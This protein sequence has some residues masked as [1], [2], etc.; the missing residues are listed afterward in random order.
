MG[1]RGT[2]YQPGNRKSELVP[3]EQPGQ[4]LERPLL[5]YER[6]LIRILGC[7]EREYRSYVK[8]VEFKSKE[9][10][11][12]YELIPDISCAPAV[13]ILINLAIG[14]ALTAVA[15]LLAPKPQA[16]KSREQ[17]QGKD[18]RLASKQGGERFGATSGF[19]SINDLANFAEP[20][21]VIFAK[22]EQKIG[23]VLAAGQLVWSRAYSYGSGQGL[24]LMYII[25]EQGLLGEGIDRP[26]LQGIYLGTTALDTLSDSK[27]AFYWNR[28]T[29]INGRIKAKNLAYGTRA[30]PSA[31]DPQANDDIFLCPSG[32]AANDT[33]FSQSYT[34]TSNSIFGCYGA[35][36][37]G[38]GYRV[39]FE[40]V[41]LPR[42][43]GD[44]NP[45]QSD[46]ERLS[47]SIRRRQK[48]SGDYNS[49]DDL[50]LDDA[51]SN[52]QRG[53]G[54]E[55][56]RHMGLY[57]LNNQIIAPGGPNGHKVLA[58]VKVGDTA[59]FVIEGGF[60]SEDKYWD[61]DDVEDVNTD[62]INNAT[63]RLR[64]EADDILQVGQ[65][66]MIGQTVW[67][68]RA[69]T[70]ER[71]GLEA[72]GKPI[73][74][75]FQRRPNQD[76]TLEC[77]ESFAVDPLRRQIGFVSNEAITRSIRT[78]DQGNKTYDYNSD[79]KIGL[80]IGPGFFPLMQVN[81]A[82]V[83][84]TRACETT[85]FGIKS[86]VWNRASGLCNFSSLP[87]PEGLSEA[88]SRGDSFRSGVMNTYFTRSS[89]FTIFLRPA[90]T[91][92]DGKEYTWTPI[93][94]Q[95]VVT[96]KR[97]VDQYN[98]LRF[99]HPEIREY[100]FKFVPKPGAD[101]TQ[102]APD[103][104]E[105]IL[106]D[107]TLVNFAQQGANF[108]RNYST[109]YGTFLVQC[110]G[111]PILKGSIEF[112]PE[113]STGVK[114]N[115]DGKG[116]V[117]AVPK[118]IIIAGYT[119]D[120][121]EEDSK[122]I[123]IAQTGDGWSSLP[124][125]TQYRQSAFFWE[126]FGQAAPFNRVQIF[127]YRFN[128]LR[129][130]TPGGPD[131]WIRIQFEG[132][133]NQYFPLNHPEFPG[134]RAWSLRSIKVLESSGGMNT[135]DTFNC[136]VPTRPSN[137]RNPTQVFPDGTRGKF[138]EV[139]VEIAVTQTSALK[140]LGG[141]QNAYSYEVLGNA[142]KYRIGERRSAERTLRIGSKVTKVA[143]SAEVI[144]ATQELK[145]TFGV[146]Q[147]YDKE[148]VGPVA[149][150]TFGDWS[151]QDQVIDR[152]RITNGNPYKSPPVLNGETYARVGIIYQ[153]AGLR[154]EAQAPGLSAD[155]V[156]EENAGITDLSNYTERTTSNTSGPEHQI[157]YVSETLKSRLFEA[158]YD[159]LTSCGLAI[160]SDKDFT[161]ADQ[162]RVWLYG[163]IEVKR[164]HPSEAGTIGTSNLLPDLVYHLMTDTTAGL[165]E[166]VSEE[167]LDLPSFTK[168]CQ[169]LRLNKLFF[170]GAISEPQNLRDYITTIAPFFLLDFAIINGQFSFTP[171]IP[172]NENGAISTGAV[173]VSA[174]FSD[175]NI[176]EGTFEVEY[177]EADQ[178]RDFTAAMRWRKEE[179][180]KFP[181]EQVAVVRWNE[182]GSDLYPLEA[183]DMT[184]YCCSE[185]HAVIAAKYLM[186]LRR[187]V[188]HTVT[189]KTTPL[190]LN[191]APGQYIK[192]VTQA[193]PYQ[194]A[195]NGVIEDDGT[196]VMSTDIADGTYPIFYFDFAKDDV[197][198]GTMT[199]VNGSVTQQELWGTIVTLRYEGISSQI[200]QVQQLTLDEE[201][202]VEIVALEHPTTAGGVSEIALDLIQG[203]GN[204]RRDY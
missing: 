61:D 180:N 82:S 109:P 107:S 34:P 129:P 5:P 42:T 184:D 175:G 137:P 66:V 173:P 162:L 148:S 145:D 49:S 4:L 41:P 87:T 77:I 15:V 76:I 125:G 176:I 57:A 122:A 54:R 179:V 105:F 185:E 142:E 91:D 65:T 169:F 9:R 85:E 43:Q 48:V 21:A 60:V 160:R 195:N 86:Q 196:L 93:N 192:V 70:L 6:E 188:T 161:R 204:F 123:A 128:G 99:I 32:K 143:Y 101:L 25:G 1:K 24:K 79:S 73:I 81:L 166:L 154:Q 120:I 172:I 182:A 187:R 134:W 155:R 20:I 158:N 35:I 46:E 119:P 157:V 127:N 17:R 19:D 151:R 174:L 74:G 181:E 23:G 7:T 116:K 189:F 168:A 102:F 165:G 68:V 200:Y 136:R 75:P 164:F 121:E 47:A 177:L 80:T 11:A 53:V 117:V 59:I 89:V 141:R 69:R 111:R 183:F 191:L 171:A 114:S 72:D 199:V 170:N 113:M 92:S 51:I 186:S 106:L 190:G 13:P 18:I 124:E 167:L 152:V 193:S 132:I 138:S 14:I 26:D 38:T 156:F 150:S 100:E 16:P 62:D 203:S 71:F 202:L 29:R 39:N 67:I 144:A 28:N 78:D 30:I 131:R 56:S 110:S 95:F 10:P 153:I 149:N 83:R 31:G 37:N 108:Q 63:I 130:A 2:P 133:V 40:L 163:G 52:G 139:G 58:N 3:Y 64:E 140:S 8:K 104:A 194:A 98:F 126:I 118:D 197:V 84:N 115:E 12:G 88:D 97:P 96:G 22:R 55:Y 146:T 201:G 178:R 103:D 198:T 94:E 112:A 27:Y 36:A 90:G 33:A 44:E 147:V 45:D 50:D 159:K 135:G